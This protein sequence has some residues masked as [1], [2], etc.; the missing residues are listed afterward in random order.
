MAL[1][2][3]RITWTDVSGNVRTT[4]L[5]GV[6]TMSV[7]ELALLTSSNG[8]YLSDSEAEVFANASP[9]PAAAQYQSVTDTAQLWLVTTAGTLVQVTIPA[10][11]LSIFMADQE[12][13]NPA[14]V[15]GIVSQCVGV[16]C[17]LAGNLVT[18]YAAGRRAPFPTGG[19]G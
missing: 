2:T 4:S 16:I 14:S 1:Y 6:S 13:V 12:T 18:G 11:K 7:I 9:S 5:L 15:A 17:D 8:D 3:R 10:P 19:T